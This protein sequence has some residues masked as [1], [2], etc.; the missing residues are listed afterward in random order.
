MHIPYFAVSFK[1]VLKTL[2]VAEKQKPYY[3]M[4]TL[5]PK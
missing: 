1:S 2:E 4:C 5:I 3:A